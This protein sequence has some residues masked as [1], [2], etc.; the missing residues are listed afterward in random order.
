MNGLEH[1]AKVFGSP[2]PRTP[3]GLHFSPRRALADV[4]NDLMYPDVGAGWYW[5]RFLYLF[6]PGLDELHACLDAWPF[7]VAPR[8]PDRMILGRNAYGAILFIDRVN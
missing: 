7:L 4:W 8:R 6:G 5:D 1:F 2:K 3:S